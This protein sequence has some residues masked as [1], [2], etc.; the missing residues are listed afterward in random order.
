[1]TTIDSS[2]DYAVEVPGLGFVTGHF[3]IISVRDVSTE[4]AYVNDH[5]E[6]NNLAKT[7]AAEYRRLGLWD[8]ANTVRVVQRTVTVTRG[9]WEPVDLALST[10][11]SQ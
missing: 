2:N 10:K 6:A 7:V 3:P 1:M 8:I 4:A 11:E 5:T 9:D